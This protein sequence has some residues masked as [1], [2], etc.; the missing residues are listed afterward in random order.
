MAVVQVVAPEHSFALELPSGRVAVGR[1]GD[2]DIV[3]KDTQASRRHCILIPADGG[4]RVQD[5]GSRNGTTFNDQPIDEVFVPFGEPFAIGKTKLRVFEG[6]DTPD[7]DAEPALE[8]AGPDEDALPALALPEERS[9]DID[10]PLTADDVV[11]RAKRD[12]NNLRNAGSDPGFSFNDL[13]FLDCHGQPLHAGTDDAQASEAVKTLRFLFYGAFRTRA[14]DIHLE[15]AEQ[16]CHIRFRVDG[17]MLPIVLLPHPVGRAALNV[18]RVLAELDTTRKRDIQDGSFT[19]AL[20][21]RVDCRISLS[22]TMYGEKLV[23]R[24][25]DTAVLPGALDQIGLPRISLDQVRAVC[26]LDSG[27]MIVSG[28]TGSGKTTT[29]YTCLR[30]LDI[31]SRNVVT[32][33]D[34]I[35]YHLGGI[36]Q[37]QTDAKQG[38][39]FEHVLKSVLRQDPDVMLIGEIR[40]GQTAQTAMQAAM[41]GHLVFT[42]LHARD[43]IGSIFRLLD[44]GVEAYLIAHAVSVCLSQRLVRRLC[45]HCCKP[46]RPRPSEII[47]MKMENRK[48]KRLYASVG[49]R[50]C[51]DVG[52]WGRTAIFELLNFNDNLRDALMTTKT[53]HDI[54]KA[55]GEWT[56]QTLLEAGYQKVVEGVTTTEEVERVA[57][58]E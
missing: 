22:P 27:M 34:P 17:K 53:I 51:M 7:D 28:P 58:R 30:A 44:L 50:R 54:R 36:T 31:Q 23:A 5:L 15:P 48:I 4:Y 38:L 16:G 46:F 25:L 21:R 29:L 47:R 20:P 49:C 24:I 18:I 40:D 43:A 35:E 6:I 12:L 2:N 14:T 9:D 13:T 39:T 37:I 41:T 11:A 42:T 1:G 57:A 8:L 55:A 10:V 32:I 56:Y 26:R 33:E 45:P 3:I 19:I 52:F